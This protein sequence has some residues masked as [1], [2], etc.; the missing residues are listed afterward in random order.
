VWGSSSTSTSRRHGALWLG[1]KQET[2]ATQ[3][4]RSIEDVVIP[5]HEA[6]VTK[7]IE[8]QVQR[9]DANWLMLYRRT[10]DESTGSMEANTV[11]AVVSL[12]VRARA[13]VHA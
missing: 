7:C 9:E 3:A 6:E 13:P 8:Q 1:Q 11:N 2:T 4:R 12:H 5:L 10:L